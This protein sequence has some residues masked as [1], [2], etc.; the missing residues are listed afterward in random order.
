MNHVPIYHSLLYLREIQYIVLVTNENSHFSVF[1][2][3]NMSY[4]IVYNET[5]QHQMN[6]SIYVFLFLYNIVIFT[7]SCHLIL[8]NMI[9]LHSFLLHSI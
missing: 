9:L 6:S 3:V 7:K 4:F 1:I 5:N 2:I 8:T